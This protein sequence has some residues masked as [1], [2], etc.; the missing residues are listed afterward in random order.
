MTDNKVLNPDDWMV[1]RGMPV[2][3]AR[4]REIEA[5]FN[6]EVV[7][8]TQPQLQA[9]LDQQLALYRFRNGWL[10]NFPD[11][12][13]ITKTDIFFYAEHTI[14]MIA[15]GLAGGPVIPTQQNPKPIWFRKRRN[16]NR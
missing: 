2:P 13:V 4:I 16:L 15:L 10:S 11:R 7:P 14:P 8:D 5:V 3:I 9:D 6:C 1:C 12:M